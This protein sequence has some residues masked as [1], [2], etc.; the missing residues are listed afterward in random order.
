MQQ[1]YLR[2]TI[3]GHGDYLK[4]CHTIISNVDNTNHIF[5]NYLYPINYKL[6]IGIENSVIEKV[7]RKQPKV[8]KRKSHRKPVRKV[9]RASTDDGLPNDDSS[10]KIEF[11]KTTIT[12]KRKRSKKTIQMIHMV[13]KTQRFKQLKGMIY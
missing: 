13:K 12:K 11:V 3:I 9:L 2:S 4:T 7:M 5:E 8:T 6:L 1:V 10:V